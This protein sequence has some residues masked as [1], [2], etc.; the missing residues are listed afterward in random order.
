MVEVA[1]VCPV[2]DVV[3]PAVAAVA[4]SVEVDEAWMAVE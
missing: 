4:G 1:V 2:V 3:R